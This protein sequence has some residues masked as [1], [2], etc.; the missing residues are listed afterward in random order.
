MYT[1]TIMVQ[2][3]KKGYN[4]QSGGEDEKAEGG[5]IRLGNMMTSAGMVFASGVNQAAIV[6]A[7]ARAEG[8]RPDEL[9]KHELKALGFQSAPGF[10]FLQEKVNNILA[11]LA[12]SIV[13]G[14]GLSFTH[15]EA[16]HETAECKGK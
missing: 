6:A 15:S 11:D 13:K 7:H 12:E 9:S 1:A 8:R 10:E 5:E 14:A 3:G 4:I 16:A 2:K